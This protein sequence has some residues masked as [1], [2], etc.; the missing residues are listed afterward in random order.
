MDHYKRCL[1]K[2]QVRQDAN[3]STMTAL[4]KRMAHGQAEIREL[5]ASQFIRAYFNVGIICDRYGDL[6]AAK[7][8]YG[9]AV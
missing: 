3:E 5:F 8:W 4:E 1:R 6:E 7:A 9:R 2:D